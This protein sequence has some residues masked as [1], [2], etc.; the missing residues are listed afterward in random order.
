MW[1]EKLGSKIVSS[2]KAACRN[3]LHLDGERLGEFEAEGGLGG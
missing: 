2:K 1:P 3:S